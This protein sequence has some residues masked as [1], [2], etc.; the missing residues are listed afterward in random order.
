M[1]RRDYNNEERDVFNNDGGRDGFIPRRRF[2]F[3]K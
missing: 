2:N 1:D 3:S